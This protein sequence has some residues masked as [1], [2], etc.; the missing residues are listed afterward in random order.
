MKPAILIALLL[1]TPVYAQSAQPGQ[2]GATAE[3][4]TP[5]APPK[6]RML[7]VEP[8]TKPKGPA[9]PPFKNELPPVRAGVQ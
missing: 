5:T 7:P 9:E 2:A 1:A 8:A 6:D 4:F 3:D